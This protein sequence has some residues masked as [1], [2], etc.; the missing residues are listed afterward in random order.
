MSAF[1]KRGLNI[2]SLNGSLHPGPGYGAKQKRLPLIASL[3]LAC[4]LAHGA[5]CVQWLKRTDVGS[6][7]QRYNHAMAYDSDRGVTVFFGGEIGNEDDTEYFNDT[8]EYDG[9]QW[10]QISTAVKPPKRS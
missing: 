3:L 7:G 8:Q 5:D 10:K 9:K 4:A 1:M 6:Y 2:F